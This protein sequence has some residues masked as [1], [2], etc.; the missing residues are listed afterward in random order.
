[1]Q[2]AIY[3]INAEKRHLFYHNYL[4]VNLPVERTQ[5]C[6]DTLN[7]GRPYTYPRG[8]RRALVSLG[9]NNKAENNL[10][11]CTT[12][13]W[14]EKSHLI[15]R[16]ADYDLVLQR[17]NEKISLSSKGYV[18]KKDPLKE[19]FMTG[20]KKGLVVDQSALKSWLIQN[21]EARGY[22][23]EEHKRP[24]YTHKDIVIAG[25]LFLC[26]LVMLYVFHDQYKAAPNQ[27]EVFKIMGAGVVGLVSLGYAIKKWFA[28]KN[29][30]EPVYLKNK[31]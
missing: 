25:C 26:A 21:L 29:I 30:T 7:A 3:D 24:I 5:E 19:W 9:S 4:V 28:V 11:I 27:T 10:D 2:P 23:L 6:L 22:K 12:F 16:E 18:R 15:M 8:A 14:D 17:P 31:N 20:S 1:M 13:I